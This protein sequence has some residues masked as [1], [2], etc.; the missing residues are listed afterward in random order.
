MKKVLGYLT[1][2]EN[3]IM[4]VTFAIMVVASFLQ[5]VNRNITKFSIS[6][7]DEAATYCMIYMV[8]IG[9]EMGLR[10]GTQIAVTGVV[11]KLHGAAKIAVQII[12]KV[13][14]VAFSFLVFLGG[15]QLMN[16]QIRTGQVSAALNLPMS[17]PYAAMVISFAIITLVQAVDA[18]ELAVRL[19][20]K[21][22][23]EGTNT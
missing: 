15:V 8:L 20:K 1:K 19:I 17:V 2:L 4:V 14:V 9:T 12:A 11:D 22:T 16:I 5:V 3:F 7:F 18:V 21:D 13:I 23:E 6:W 10:D